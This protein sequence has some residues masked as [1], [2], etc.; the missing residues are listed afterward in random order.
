MVAVPTVFWLAG[1]V[2]ASAVLRF[3]LGRQLPG[4]W[5]KP[6]ELIYSELAKSLAE[7]G[8]FA[9]RDVPGLEYGPVYSL[10]ISPAYALFESVPAAYTAA[11]AINAV[12]MSVAAVPTYLLARRVLA[13]ALSLVAALLAVAVPSMAY[14][15]LIMT[16]AAFYPVFLF[17]VLAIVLALERPSVSR[18]LLALALI[19][20]A[21]LTR[22]QALALVPAYATAILLV[23]VLDA[24]ATAR[25]G[26]GRLLGGQ[27]A[28]FTPTWLAL[29]GLPLVVISVQLLR[30]ES[31]ASLLRGYASVAGETYTPSDV[32]RWFL[33]HLAEFDLYLGV[34][35][36]AALL[37]LV[38]E[39]L[40][41]GEVSRPL[42]IF[43][44]TAV[45]ACFWLTLLV[46][47][48]ASQP[49]IQYV[50]ERYLFYLAPLFFV[51]LLAWIERGLPRPRLPTALAAVAAAALPVVLPYE[52]LVRGSIEHSHTLAL[53]PLWGVER[54]LP[55]PDVLP[56]VVT[57]AA[58]AAALGFLVLPRRLALLAPAVVLLYFAVASEPI[59]DWFQDRA[60]GSLAAGISGERDWIDEAVGTDADVAVVF[61]GGSDWHAVWEN[62][63]FNRSVGPLYNIGPEPGGN[64]HLPD[65]HPR[66]DGE[67]GVL[68]D[69]RNVPMTAEY[70]LA[71]RALSLDGRVV[72]R[73]R[74]IG[75]LLY[76]VGGPIAVRTLTAGLYP[77]DQWSGPEVTFARFACQGGT[78][79]ALVGSDASLFTTPQTVTASTAGR[80]VARATLR[81]GA[82][83]RLTV[84][85]RRE[86]GVCNVKFAVS[87]TA[88]PADVLG[89]EDGREL[90]VRFLRIRYVG[91]PG[92]GR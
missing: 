64:L 63:F 90:G 39:A 44:A 30:G 48:F 17:T 38:G 45:A 16:E 26:F 40:S 92:E 27:V 35:P 85:L 9:V 69:D 66:I 51:A 24:R 36:F 88:V 91:A 7:S 31:L 80:E 87:P 6:D 43:A 14:T 60:A 76:R 18:Q 25:G 86:Q 58:L 32:A 19:A 50:E 12:L 78:L 59:Q 56:L 54:R 42:R 23:A 3:A 15:G 53:M 79:V 84:P 22:A 8:T 33:Y 21:L 2:A 83:R 52:T 82:T 37:L 29:V 89:S 71:D 13:R 46:A 28:R 70:A 20:L 34:L 67:T 11:K 4:I 81:P 57:A 61:S 75:M 77:G 5:I 73:D 49:Y 55:S 47:A 41:R 62:E 10:L 1:I 68:L 74:A 65:T 72:A